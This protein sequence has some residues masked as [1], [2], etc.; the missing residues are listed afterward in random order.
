MNPGVMQEAF[1][2]SDWWNLEAAADW[3]FTTKDNRDNIWVLKKTTFARGNYRIDVLMNEKM[4]SVY[5]RI[6]SCGS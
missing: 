1:Y 3:R 5:F 2:R 6:D 4:H